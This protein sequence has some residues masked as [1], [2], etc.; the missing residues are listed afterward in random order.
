MLKSGSEFREFSVLTVRFPN[1][2]TDPTSRPQIEVEQQRVTKGDA[3]DAEVLAIVEKYL[4][5]V[6]FELVVVVY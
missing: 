4:S 6:S 1:Q 3:P 2:G 5:K